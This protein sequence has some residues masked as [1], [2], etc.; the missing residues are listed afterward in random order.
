MRFACSIC[1]SEATATLAASYLAAGFVHGVLNSDNIS[2]TGESFDYGPWRFTPFWDPQFTAAYFDHYGL[3]AFGRQAEAIRWNVAQLAGSLSIL[4]E[5]ASLSKIL[6]DWSGRFE[7][8]MAGAMLVRLG[9]V[10]GDKDREI[11]GTLIQA[12]ST[13]AEPIDRFFFDWRGGRDPGKDR[14][15][16]DEFR[17][18]AGLMTCRERTPTQPYWSREAPAPCT[19]M[20]SRRSGR[21]LRCQTTGSR[22]TRRLRRSVKWPMP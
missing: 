22:L 9:I 11:T 8:A 19:S 2:V 12:L 20:K 17:K 14:Y 5:P 1:V 4:A 21:Q 13:R 18:L 6:A 3:Y 15:P 10:R 7:K 16:A